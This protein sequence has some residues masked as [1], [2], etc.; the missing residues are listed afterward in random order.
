MTPV[1]TLIGTATA[2]WLSRSLHVVAT[3][4]VA[5]AIGDAPRDVQAVAR[6][7]GADAA[8]LSRVVRLLAAYGIFT[9]DGHMVGHT[10][11]SLMLRSDHPQTLRPFVRFVGSPMCWNGFRELEYAVCTGSPA[12]NKIDPS[13]VFGYFASHPEESV[14]FNDAMTAR[15]HGQVA[16]VLASY[17]FSGFRTVADIGGGRGHL[18]HAVV[19]ANPGVTGILFDR[20]QVV[21]EAQV[22]ASDRL[23]LQRGDFFV[24]PLPAAD[25]YLIME[26]IHDWE[27]SKA[28]AI[29]RAIRQAASASSVLLL[30]ENIVPDTAGPHW[31]KALDLMMMV[32]PGGR[33]RTRA[34][35]EA[36]LS[37]ADFRVTRI[38][39]TATISIIEARPK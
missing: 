33:E 12:I 30:L 37:H 29:L 39:E 7:S 18:I 16:S 38:L 3:L 19:E 20:P 27:E 31:A 25:A 24:D 10:P 13:G 1:E 11:A 28:I 36:L 22:I 17:D 5:D 4:G 26:V 14:L 21:S 32:G 15:A 9:H 6:E 8:A 34:E 23:R 2:Y 35:Y